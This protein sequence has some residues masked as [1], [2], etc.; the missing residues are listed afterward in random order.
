MYKIAVISGKGGTGKTF[1]T[2]ALTAILK[3]QII[4]DCDV[5][6]SNLYLM[7]NPSDGIRHEFYGGKTAVIDSERCIDCG[8]CTENCRY[9]AI[10]ENYNV[11]SFLCEG[12]SLCFHL[13]PVDAVQMKTLKAGEY[14]QA[15]TSLGPFVYAEMTPGSENSGK[16]VNEIKEAAGRITRESPVEFMLLDG[17]PGTS[18]PL[19]STVAGCH[20]AIIVT[21]P[22]LSGLHDL[23]RVYA[24]VQKFRTSAGVV[25]NKYDLS[26]EQT[27]KIEEYCAQEDLTILGKIPYSTEIAESLSRGENVFEN[28]SNSIKQEI[29]SIWERTLVM[30]HNRRKRTKQYDSA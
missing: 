7:L 14:Y 22:T 20:A 21:E 26:P 13:C 24:V 29:D 23:Q 11:D 19:I 4:L 2:S 27:E 10:D 8:I 3:R 18:C 5:D 17:P 25:I 30:L 28:L 16:L 12:C 9:G 6:A 15:E 1:L